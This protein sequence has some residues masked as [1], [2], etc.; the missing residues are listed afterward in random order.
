MAENETCPRLPRQRRR[1]LAICILLDF[2]N[3][4]ITVHGDRPRGLGI[5]GKTQIILRIIL[6]MHIGGGVLQFA[7]SGG[8][9]I[10]RT[11]Y[12]G[13]I[14]VM[15]VGPFT[16]RNLKVFSTSFQARCDIRRC[17]SWGFWKVSSVGRSKTLNS[18]ND[19]TSLKWDEIMRWFNKPQKR[20]RSLCLAPCVIQ[21]LRVL[22]GVSL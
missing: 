12:T 20:R 14:Q 2:Y 6:Y 3:P 17:W 22:R 19:R 1:P 16:F 9:S 13:I 5:L 18:C 11:T 15:L 8:R 7:I 4:K 21:L 10:Y